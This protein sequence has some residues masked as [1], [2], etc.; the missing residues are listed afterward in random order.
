[1]LFLS[2]SSFYPLDDN[3][4]IDEKLCDLMLSTSKLIA[5]YS[6]PITSQ[7]IYVAGLWHTIF[8]LFSASS[9]NRA[10]MI[11]THFLSPF[12]KE[13]KTLNAIEITDSEASFD[14][15]PFQ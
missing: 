14:N 4:I 8:H 11:R 15:V 12:S 2:A 1:L 7:L 13:W 3:S 6:L 10:V 5:L 9:I